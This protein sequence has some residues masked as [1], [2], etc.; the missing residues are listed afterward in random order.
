MCFRYGKPKEGQ[1]FRTSI[2]E[3][4]DRSDGKNSGK[5]GKKFDGPKGKKFDRKGKNFDGPKGKFDGPKGSKFDKKGQN[6]D[7]PGRKNNVSFGEKKFDGPASK[8]SQ[9]PSKPRAQG[10]TH[11]EKVT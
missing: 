5:G 1:R 10:E 4:R 11:G 3:K 6:I 8:R 9:E 2:F 7:G